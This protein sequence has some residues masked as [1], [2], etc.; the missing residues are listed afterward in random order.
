MIE[1]AWA[2]LAPYGLAGVGLF[3]FGWT[4]AYLWKHHNRER[5]AMLAAAKLERE[6]LL[7]KIEVLQAERIADMKASEE[8]HVGHVR[9]VTRAMSSVSSSLDTS[10]SAFEEVTAAISRKR[11]G[12]E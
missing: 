3:V 12:D 2:Q 6:T 5:D 8:E 11:G 10:R 7:S 4:I 1:Q 9:E